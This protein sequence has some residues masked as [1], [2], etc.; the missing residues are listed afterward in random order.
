[1]N[2][3]IAFITLC[4][5]LTAATF[6]VFA[7]QESDSTYTFRLAAEEAVADSLA[8]SQ[9]LVDSLVAEQAVVDSLA[10][11]GAEV[12]SMAEAVSPVEEETV[13]QQPAVEEMAELQTAEQE[14]VEEETVELQNTVDTPSETKVADDYQFALRA[15]LLRWATLTP[16]VGI[17]WRVSPSVGIVVNG[18]WTAW[19]WKDN[20]RRY[21]LWEVMPE[22]RWYLDESKD[23]YVGAM[24]KAGQFNYNLA[25]NGRQ[26][27]IMGGGFTGGYQLR[28][29]NA[30]SLDFSLALGYLHS[31]Y[32]R[33]E[34][35]NGVPECV[36]EGTKN[37]WG[38]INAGVTLV[39]KLF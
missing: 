5:W 15:N 14:M 13:E 2:R 9:A 18:T 34:V 24:F 26:G 39:W 36:E 37:W 11:K 10:A 1:M 8:S 23:W 30:L 25:D 7:Q 12:E 19:T 17:E 33:Y 38:P 29:S 6:P 3:K 4:L 35:T 16:D 22:V 21:A 32:E 28:L 31:D 27:D 20:N